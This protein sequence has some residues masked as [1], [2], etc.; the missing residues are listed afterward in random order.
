MKWSTDNGQTWNDFLP[1]TGSQVV[2][3]VTLDNDF[4]DYLNS[5]DWAE[6]RRRVQKDDSISPASYI[7]SRVHSYED[8]KDIR[9]AFIEGISALEIALKSHVDDRDK[10][11][12]FSEHINQFRDKNRIPTQFVIMA[13]H[14]G[15]ISK[16]DIKSVIKAIKIRNK[17]IH[18]NYEPRFDE[19]QYLYT[20]C[21]VLPK[22]L[23]GP[24]KWKFPSI[25]HGNQLLP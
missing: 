4:S 14:K 7:T 10:N 6:I 8:Q 9:R 16:K 2:L 15:T 25:H 17:I 13:L 11:G 19:I 23:P 12:D 20:L 5:Y 22:I 18:E 3:T 21:R 1:D 24:S